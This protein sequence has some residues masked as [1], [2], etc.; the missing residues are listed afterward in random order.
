MTQDTLVAKN[1]G[2]YG[3][4]EAEKVL[5]VGL[6]TRA[7]LFKYTTADETTIGM[8]RDNDNAYVD[9]DERSDMANAMGC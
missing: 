4:T 8:T 1:S 6:A 3:Y 7:F 2:L 5:R 9:L